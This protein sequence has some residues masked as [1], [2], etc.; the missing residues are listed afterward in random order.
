MRLLRTRQPGGEGLLQALE[1]L[2]YFEGE[3]FALYTRTAASRE[4]EK[5][6]K[7]SV[8][9]SYDATTGGVINSRETRAKFLLTI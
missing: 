6:S 9:N 8:K 5:M 1:D 3:D 2:I 4:R 7:R